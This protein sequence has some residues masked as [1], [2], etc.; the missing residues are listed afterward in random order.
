MMKKL[1]FLYL[2]PYFKPDD[3]PNK[4]KFTRL[5]S[6]YEG[7]IIA[8]VNRKE[9]RHFNIGN[10]TLKG[11][12][13]PQSI[14]YMNLIRNFLYVIFTFL[15]VIY[16]HYF[17]RRYDVIITYDPFATGLLALIIS[18]VTKVKF[19]VEV[20]GN[21]KAAFISDPKN[22][23]FSE[24]LK[25][26]IIMFIIPFVLKRTD[27][28]KL[29][30][31]N[32]LAPFNGLKLS[33]K[34][35]C[36]HDFVPISHFKPDIP[37]EAKYILF[38]G[39]PWF[40]KGVDILLK[41]FNKISNDYPEY[42]LKI[43]G[44]CN[45]KTY[46]Q[47]LAENNQQIQLCNPVHYHEAIKLM[48]GCS[49]FILPSRT[50]AMGRVLLEAM[51]S[52]KPIIA[53]NVDGIPTYIKH[54]YNGLLFESENIDDLAEKMKTILGNEDYAKQIAE[55]GY[56]Y[57]YERLSEDCYVKKFRNMIEKTLND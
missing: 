37:S 2:G 50:E 39:F 26:K 4:E 5:S 24:K 21:Y 14:R 6:F 43:V 27:R 44:Y 48:E 57:V 7:D 36:F 23:K 40:L 9:F 11:L 13:L 47:Q 49:L 32:Q 34:V 46:Y 25:K 3:L 51:A 22:V 45:D 42:Y 31:E 56:K 1:L 17:K 28:V 41:A 18:K 38:L 8:V 29:L 30:Y 16:S 53:C 54:G 19:I 33:K 20:N 15:V 52:K 35:E 12:Y 10:F 55:N